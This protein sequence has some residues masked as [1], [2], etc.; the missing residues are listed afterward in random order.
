MVYYADEIT[1]TT[2]LATS[3]KRRSTNLRLCDNVFDNR[4]TP[5]QES[6]INARA[7]AILET[8]RLEL[9]V[10]GRKHGPMHSAHEAY[11]II[12][13]ELDEA[14]EEIKAKKPDK[15]RLEEELMQVAAMAVRAIIDV[16]D[17]MTD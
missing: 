6:V 15:R 10:A 12:L 9:L 17:K 2:S 5:E 7:C 13:E 8:I 16:T 3:A 4:M 11:A 14:W 1:I